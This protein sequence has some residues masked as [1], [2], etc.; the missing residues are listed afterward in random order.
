MNHAIAESYSPYCAK[1]PGVWLIE[2][3]DGVFGL[4]YRGKSDRHGYCHL[5]VRENVERTLDRI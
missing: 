2:T 4:R 3:A 1:T 5:S